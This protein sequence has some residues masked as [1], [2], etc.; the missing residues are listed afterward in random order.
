MLVALDI[1]NSTIVAALF[2]DEKKLAEQTVSS[3]QQRSNEEAWSI[4][5]SLL[6]SSTTYAIDGV[7]ISSVVPFHTNLFATLFR[8]KL[9]ID[10]LVINGSLNVGMKIHYDNPSQLGP[11]RICS[12]VAAY[13]KF[14][15]PLI[16]ID[17]GTA[18]TYGVID[19]NGDFLGGAISLGVKSTAE[20]LYRRTAQLPEIQ[21]ALPQSP[22][23]MNTIAAM[24]AGTMFSAIDSVEGM[25]K[26]IRKQLGVEAKVVATGGLSQLM[27]KQTIV[28]DVCEP[29]LV[30]EGVRLIYEKVHIR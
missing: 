23:A 12:A 1:G 16:V 4:I 14:G 2:D 15:G 25:V 26:R 27:S 13:C 6:Q 20:A 19:V 9:T 7:G 18:T 17:F 8:K 28:I 24:Q 21:L 5:T 29:S 22:I 10:P 11:D 30:L 3:T